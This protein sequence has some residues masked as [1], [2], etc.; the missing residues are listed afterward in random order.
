MPPKAQK[1]PLQTERM[2]KLFRVAGHGWAV[3]QNGAL[4]ELQSSWLSLMPGGDAPVLG[5]QIDAASGLEAPVVPTKIVCIGLNYAQHAAE[6]NKQVPDEPLFFLKP[7]TALQA[8]GAAIRLPPQ[9]HEVHHEGELAV[10]I[11]RTLTRA[12]VD[13]A[14]AAIFGYTCANDVTAR[15]I[16]RRESRYTRAKGFDTFCPL[17]PC[18]VLAHEFIP[19]EHSVEL[20]VNGERRQFSSLNDF[21]FP[22]GEAIA[23]ISHVMTLLPGD[24]VLTGTPSGVGPMVAGDEVSVEIDGIGVL[25]NPVIAG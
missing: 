1:P 24:V 22:L 19:E 5:A 18:V 6:M 14:K 13:E 4:H 3:E 11:G 9:S 8:P 15:D 17:G 21:I 7:T 10:V 20:R 25:T 23:F 12:S 16:Q 2:M